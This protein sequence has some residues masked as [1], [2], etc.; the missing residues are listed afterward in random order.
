MYFEDRSFPDFIK[1]IKSVYWYRS[2]QNRTRSKISMKDIGFTKGCEIIYEKKTG[3]FFLHYQVE[4][5][6]YPEE[7]MRDNTHAKYESVCFTS[8]I[9][10][11]RIIALDPGVRKFL[12]GY[13]PGGETIFVGEGAREELT[14]LLHVIDG[15]QSR[16]EDTYLDWKKVKNMVKELHWKTISFLTENY[17]SII[18]PEFKVSEMMKGHQLTREVKRQMQAFSFFQFKEK[19]IYKCKQHKKKLYIVD[20]SYTSRTCSNCGF[21]KNNLKGAEVYKCTK[22]KAILD[23]DV[24]GAKNIFLKNIL[25]RSGVVGAF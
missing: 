19:L 3:K 1:K 22:C 24:N 2:A 18:Y 4:Q 20:E 25:P 8:P 11:G 21:L 9:E 7:L 16:K 13:D 10:N 15:K 5:D 17:D 6:W 23:R 12:V 14:S